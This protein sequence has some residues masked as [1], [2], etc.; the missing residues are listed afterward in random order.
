M[1]YANSIYSTSLVRIAHTSPLGLKKAWS[2]KAFDKPK[3]HTTLT[4]IRRL[5]TGLNVYVQRVYV[6]I[7]KETKAVGLT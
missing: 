4:R 7:K 3:V 6:K 5:V 2:K 1:L